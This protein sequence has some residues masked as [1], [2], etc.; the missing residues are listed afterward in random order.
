[1]ELKL[2]VNEQVRRTIHINPWRSAGKGMNVAKGEALLNLTQADWCMTL[3]PYLWRNRGVGSLH[4]VPPQWTREHPGARSRVRPFVKDGERESL[5]WMN[6]ATRT[7]P[8]L[9]KE[10]KTNAV[11][12]R[13]KDLI[14]PAKTAIKDR[15]DLPKPVNR[16]TRS[17]ECTSLCSNEQNPFAFPT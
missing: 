6:K 9:E 16:A 10:A 7:S 4:S 17:R 5:A 1:M 3:N 8:L 11:S 2:E 12:R 14:L 13:R 15:G